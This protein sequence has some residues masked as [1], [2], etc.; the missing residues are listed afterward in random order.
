MG[1]RIFLSGIDNEF[2][3]DDYV[4]GVIGSVI[5]RQYDSTKPTAKVAHAFITEAEVR[6]S[7]L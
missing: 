2:K 7:A 1:R 3:N 5:V 4:E 6:I